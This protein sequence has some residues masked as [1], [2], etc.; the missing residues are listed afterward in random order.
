MGTKIEIPQFDMY[1]QI[2][3]AEKEGYIELHHFK[4]ECDESPE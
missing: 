3:V 4:Q 1:K 2:V